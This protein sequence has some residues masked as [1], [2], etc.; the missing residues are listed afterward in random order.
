MDLV[1]GTRIEVAS[2]GVAAAYA[3]WLLRAYGA[4]VEHVS[5]LDREGIGAFLAEGARFAADPGIGGQGTTLLI[6]DA[7]VNGLNRER[8]DAAAAGRPVIWITPWGIDSDWAERPWTDLLLHAAGGW[9]H[10]VGEPGEEPLGPPGA[11]GQ[12]VAGLFATIHALAAGTETGLSVVSM[13]EAV[14][15]TT[16]YDAVAFQ[17]YGAVRARYGKRFNRAQC[18]LVNL[19]ASDGWIG[20][21]AA[22]HHQFVKLC[23]VVGHPELVSDPRFASIP[24]R[25]RHL[26]ELDEYLSA[27]T[28]QR[29]RF[30]VYHELQRA[31]IPNSP[32]PGMAEVL[33]S[34]HLAARESWKRVT[35][36]S[37]RTFQAPG[38][39]ARVIAET[40]PTAEEARP[41]GPWAPGKPRVIDFSMGWAGPLVSHVLASYGADVIKLESHTRYDWW[42]GSRPPGDDPTNQLHETS[43]VFNTVNRGKRGL[44]IDL[45]TAEGQRLARELFA[46]ADVVIENYTTGVIGKLGLDYETLSRDNPRLI[47]LHQPGFGAVGPE[48]DYVV[49]GNTIEGMSGITSMIGYDD[50]TV[51][52]QMSNAF[53]D[54]VSGLNGAIAVL[55]ALRARA[56]DGKGRCIEGAQLEGFLPLVAEHLIDYQRTGQER[57]RMG[58]RRP[59]ALV[60]GAFQ[61]AGEDRWV[62]VELREADTLAALNAL[63]GG[64]LAGWCAA[65]ERDEAVNVLVAQGIPAA[66]VNGEP[67]VL[68]NEPFAS[69]GFYVGHKREP[70]GFHLYPSLPVLRDGMRPATM[71]P[72]P[73]L[74]EHNDE[75]LA[76]LGRDEAAIDALERAGIIGRVPA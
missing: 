4:E 24:E 30:E 22:L 36:P 66:P 26:D 6:T 69:A 25:M 74:G 73:L 38:E 16:I 54:P 40:G 76:G 67:D 15:A 37:G 10:A 19:P 56:R 14:N 34:P 33:A 65:R 39:P 50:A 18:A 68:A 21:H 44:T 12:F 62:A 43:H 46:T 47:L 57:G 60:S 59:G 9:M 51:P 32:L 64:D 48:K 71:T 70:V 63:T 1:T 72:A 13:V 42:R 23:E 41:D 8:I 11:Q 27:W 58:N 75:I 17:Y 28:C 20:I 52:F 55:A 35:T 53:G 31:R 61:A 7:P 49:F 5:A 45:G 2:H 29:E 3:G